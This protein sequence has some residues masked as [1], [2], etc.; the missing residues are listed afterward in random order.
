MSIF[1]TIILFACSIL[2]QYIEPSIYIEEYQS[3]IENNV[4]NDNN[5]TG[6]DFELTN[7]IFTKEIN[8]KINNNPYLNSN[9]NNLL[10]EPHIKNIYFERDFNFDFDFE[11]DFERDFEINKFNYKPLFRCNHCKEF[12]KLNQPMHCCFDFQFCSNCYYSIK[13]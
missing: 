12:I 1:R 13:W 10:F 8:N 7:C 6:V 9:V 5:Y 2:S 3:D 4:E 11:R